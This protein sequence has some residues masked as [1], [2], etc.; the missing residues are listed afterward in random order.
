MTEQSVVPLL[1]PFWTCPITTQPAFLHHWYPPQAPNSHLEAQDAYAPILDVAWGSA[2]TS[3]VLIRMA[4]RASRFWT[5]C[6]LRFQGWFRPVR[7]HHLCTSQTG[8]KPVQGKRQLWAEL[9]RHQSQELVMQW[10]TQEEGG[11]HRPKSN[12]HLVKEYHRGRESDPAGDC[13]SGFLPN[14]QSRLCY[15]LQI[16]WLVNM[17][18]STAYGLC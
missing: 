2:F 11:G 12:P 4:P 6:P 7:S 13:E 14:H 10:V 15:T 16:I 18:A 8:S 3:S 5:S 17:G 1:P 9:N